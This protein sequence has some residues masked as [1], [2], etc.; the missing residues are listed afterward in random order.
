MNIFSIWWHRL[1][2]WKVFTNHS[3][4]LTLSKEPDYTKLTIATPLNNRTE[5]PYKV[6]IENGNV[7]V[8]RT[9]T[10]KSVNIKLTDEN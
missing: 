8:N 2:G 1:F 6:T 9:E 4:T 7:Y 3:D 5:E 10:P